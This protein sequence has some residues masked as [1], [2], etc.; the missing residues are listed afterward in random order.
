MIRIIFY[1]SLK[2]LL[3][4]FDKLAHTQQYEL[5]NYAIYKPE[6]DNYAI[7]KH[8]LYNYEL[9]NY[10]IYNYESYKHSK[11][12]ICQLGKNGFSD[13]FIQTTYRNK[14]ICSCKTA[15]SNSSQQS[16]IPR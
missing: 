3:V 7:Y 16:A 6:H 5:Y 12:E 2:P 9:Y 8:T 10:A 1:I 4:I 15:D 11:Y 13:I 14:S